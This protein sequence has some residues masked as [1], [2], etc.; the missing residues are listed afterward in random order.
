V[1]WKECKSIYPRRIGELEKPYKNLINSC[2]PNIFE[3]SFVAVG[4]F[5]QDHNIVVGFNL[6][7]RRLDSRHIA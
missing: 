2:D 1:S 3:V 6:L 4:Y 5:V 7:V